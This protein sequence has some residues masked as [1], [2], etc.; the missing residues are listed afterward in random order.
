MYNPLLITSRNFNYIHIREI[1]HMQSAVRDAKA[2][3]MMRQLR[4]ERFL[5]GLPIRPTPL[6]SRKMEKLPELNE[7][8]TEST[9]LN[10][11]CVLEDIP[12]VN[13][14]ITVSETSEDIVVS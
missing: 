3:E 12:E 9:I 14:D 5:K 13:E 10:E 8:I 6:V 2:R 7:N 4:K 11:E 1:T